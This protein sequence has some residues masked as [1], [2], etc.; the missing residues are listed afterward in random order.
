MCYHTAWESWAIEELLTTHIDTSENPA[1]LLTK[2]LYNGKQ[3][4][5]VNNI[6]YNMYNGECK[7]FSCWVSK[8]SCVQVLLWVDKNKYSRTDCILIADDGRW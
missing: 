2:V 6:L 3:R 5:S 4:D 1:N 7:Q 8:Y